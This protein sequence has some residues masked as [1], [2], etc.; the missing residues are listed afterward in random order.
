MKEFQDQ[1]AVVT[2]AAQGLGFAVAR[3]LAERGASVYLVDLQKDAVERAAGGL[4]EAGFDAVASHTDVA[5]EAQLAVLR[6]AIAARHGRVDVLINN[7]GGWRYETIR[8]ITAANWEWTF[9]VNLLSV[10]LA[11]RAF[12]EMMIAQRYGRIVN[13]ASA[14]AYRAKPTLPAYAA[15]KAG[16]LSLTKTFAL[17]LAPHQV[18]V[19]AVSPGAMATETAKSQSWLGK[20]IATIPLE[21]AAEPADMAEVIAFLASRRNRFTTGEGV[22]A[23]GGALMV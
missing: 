8:E 3:I 9:R 20:A 15:A 7:A 14:D 17:E 5:D 6:E 13:V 23:S 21:R 2:G 18:L 4:A 1:V 22:I 19:N 10:L 16:V 11:S 12:M